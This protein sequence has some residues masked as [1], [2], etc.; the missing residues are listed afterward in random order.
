MKGFTALLAAVLLVANGMFFVALADHDEHKERER[1]RKRHRN[2][3]EHNGKDK[4]KAVDNPTYKEQC[5]ACHFVYQPELLPSGSWNKILAGLDDHFGEVIEMEPGSKKII[6]DYLRANAA[7][8]SSAER[9]EKIM[10]SLGNQTPTRI[11]LIPYIQR[12]HRKIQ[13]EVLKRESIGSLSNC[14]ACHKGAENGIYDDD[15]VVIPR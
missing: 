8:Y 14:S 6:A 5:G 4:L 3:S 10:K 7:E 11:T 1:Y 12:K 2:G 15:N 13:A 9:A